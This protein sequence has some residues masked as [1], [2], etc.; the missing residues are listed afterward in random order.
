MIKLIINADDFG[1]SKVFNGKILDL[2]EKGFIKSTTVMVN[3]LDKNQETQ[4]NEL[5]GLYQANKVSVGLHLELDDNKKV[6][7]QIDEQYRKFS[8]VFGS[9]PSHLDIH[10]EHQKSVEM[11]VARFA[12]QHGLPVRNHGVETGA[13]QTTYPAFM[14]PKCIMTLDIVVDFI[15]KMK[16]E[17]SY[18]L[19][20]HP[21]EYDPNC[22]SSLN[23]E[24]KKDYDTII[25]LQDFLK[26][27]NIKNISY[28][29][30]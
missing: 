23:K 20:S 14:C 2:L 17:C 12:E 7:P 1:Y 5:K 10:K 9:G 16:E 3:R 29:E 18:E 4:I 25:R 30:L 21:G 8:K 13:K 27:H 6:N 28:L 22:R 15:K 24:R 11:E 26:L 19:V